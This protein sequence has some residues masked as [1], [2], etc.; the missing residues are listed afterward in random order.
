MPLT[1]R[2]V[3]LLW[4][5]HD[6]LARQGYVLCERTKRTGYVLCVSSYQPVHAKDVADLLARFMAHEAGD[7]GG[8]EASSQRRGGAQGL[9]QEAV[10]EEEDPDAA[11]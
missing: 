2:E 10:Q 9:D 7:E 1:E 5:Y 8:P 4:R 6:W 11:D 3:G